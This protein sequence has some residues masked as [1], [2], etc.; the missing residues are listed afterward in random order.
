MA[1]ESAAACT[2]PLRASWLRALMLERTAA[3]EAMGVSRDAGV[4]MR[5]ISHALTLAAREHGHLLLVRLPA[6]EEELPEQVLRLWAGQPGHG[7]GDRDGGEHD[8]HACGTHGAAARNS[9]FVE[10]I[11]DALVCARMIAA[12]SS[13]TRSDSS[14]LPLSSL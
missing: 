1:L 9:V 12:A 8:G 4:W 2:I 7:D 14:G 3:L 10:N 13:S 11:N 6:R 5:L